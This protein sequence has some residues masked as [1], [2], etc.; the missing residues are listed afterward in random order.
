MCFQSIH[1]SLFNCKNNQA[2]KSHGD[3]VFQ[4]LMNIG[5]HPTK[6]DSVLWLINRLS[7]TDKVFKLEPCPV[8]LEICAKLKNTHVFHSF[9]NAHL[10]L[11]NFVGV[12]EI[13]E[14]VVSHGLEDL[15]MILKDKKPSLFKHYH[16]CTRIIHN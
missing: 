8:V 14:A 5:G 13:M 3:D 9:V 15:E 16:R 10:Q 2:I 11:F 6:T 12:T 4:R 7:D 1:L